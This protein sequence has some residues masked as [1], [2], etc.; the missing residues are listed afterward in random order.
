[1]NKENNVLELFFNESSKRW[2]FEEVIKESKL[3]RD[4]TNKWLIR[5][6]KE[7]LIKKIKEKAKMPYYI[8]DFESPSYKNRKKLY[9]LERFYKTG[10]LNHLMELKEAKAVILFGSF[11][12]ADWHT[13]S[14]IDIFILGNGDKFQ[15]GLYEKKLG[16]EIQT[17]IYKEE[18]KIQKDLLKSILTGYTIKGSL[19]A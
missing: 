3:S 18:N 4:K 19:N 16:R 8:A 12:R 13:N 15:Q 14:D 17:F 6:Q 9:A 5:F 2:H 10:L 1:M 7:G 11:S